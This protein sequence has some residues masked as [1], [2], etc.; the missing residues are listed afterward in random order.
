MA[1]AVPSRLGGGGVRVLTQ[2]GW[3]ARLLAATRLARADL[4]ALWDADFLPGLKVP[5]GADTSML[6]EINVRSVTPFPEQ[7]LRP[8]AR[9]V[10]GRLGV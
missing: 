1:A 3:I 7:A 6:C 10:A 9:E 2:D 4:T 5:G 8:L